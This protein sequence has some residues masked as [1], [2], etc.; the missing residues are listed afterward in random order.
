MRHIESSRIK[1]WA[2][3]LMAVL[4]LCSL[5]G[6]AQNTSDNKD[7]KDKEK[8]EAPVNPVSPALAVDSAR[9]ASDLPPAIDTE[10]NEGETWGGFQVKQ[11]AEFGGR[12]S[13]FT[14]SQAMWDTFVNLGSGPRLLEYTLDMRSPTHSGKL[15]D[16]FSLSNFGYGGDPIDVTKLTFTK[17]RL[18]TF[19]GSFKR[20]QNIFDYDLLANPLNPATSVPNRPVL[21]SPH[22]FLLTRRMTDLN[23]GRSEE[24][25]VGKE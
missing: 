2:L 12:I 10:A 3:A 5:A 8:K 19:S 17:G 7:S 21:D 4:V 15:F 22:E 14:G 23:L 9:K 11:S 25:R 16:D 18:Y 13:D 20:D 24:R 6:F 1:T